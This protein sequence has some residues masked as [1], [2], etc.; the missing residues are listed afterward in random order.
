MRGIF[1]R[2]KDEIPSALTDR[3]SLTFGK[4][5][6]VFNIDL[7]LTRSCLKKC[8]RWDEL[9]STGEKSECAVTIGDMSETGEICVEET[10]I[11]DTFG[12]EASAWGSLRWPGACFMR[13][14][15]TYPGDIVPGVSSNS[16]HAETEARR[17]SSPKPQNARL[18]G[19]AQ[20]DH[21]SRQNWTPRV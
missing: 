4:L 19:R 1:S 3:P 17:I 9:G 10:S 11:L 20:R 7:T 8:F 14:R 12:R 21:T 6:A 16:L 13:R 15:L 5:L 2:L 18:L